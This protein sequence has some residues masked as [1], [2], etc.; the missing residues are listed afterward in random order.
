MLYYQIISNCFG[1]GIH[2]SITITNQI[3]LLTDYIFL[4]SNIAKNK[5]P[6]TAMAQP[7]TFGSGN[8]S[9]SVKKYKAT[10]ITTRFKVLPTAVGTGPSEANTMFWHS[11]YK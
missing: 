11:L 7:I 9:P 3:L 1:G 4:E 10:K 2:I 6:A 5:H 8:V